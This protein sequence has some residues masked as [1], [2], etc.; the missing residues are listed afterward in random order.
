MTVSLVRLCWCLFDLW[1]VL[2]M[3]FSVRLAFG[4]LGFDCLRVWCRMVGV[5][6]AAG[7]LGL[8]DLWVLVDLGLV[9]VGM[10]MLF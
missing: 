2:N 8:V 3:V 9:F 1:F 10:W 7:G 5:L 6:C 4:Y